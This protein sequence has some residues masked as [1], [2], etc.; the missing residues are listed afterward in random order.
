MVRIGLRFLNTSTIL[1]GDYFI[2]LPARLNK[3]FT[4]SCEKIG[5]FCPILLSCF[6]QPFFRQNPLVHRCQSLPVYDKVGF[7]VCA[8]KKCN[9]QV[10]HDTVIIREKYANLHF[11]IIKRA[12]ESKV[13]FPN[14]RG[15]NYAAKEVSGDFFG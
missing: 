14:V 10:N 12:L 3:N 5:H 4:K 7:H 2:Q 11:A 15:E 6:I 8:V 9:V 13:I 1:Y